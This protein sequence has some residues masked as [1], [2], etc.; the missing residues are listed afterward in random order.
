MDNTQAQSVGKAPLPNRSH[1]APGIS[2]NLFGRPKKN[3]TEA[4]KISALRGA[5]TG[6]I[7]VGSHQFAKDLQA[8]KPKDRLNLLM[9]MLRLVL[10]KPRPTPISEDDGEAAVTTADLL[11]AIYEREEDDDF[12]DEPSEVN[13]LLRSVAD[14]TRNTRSTRR[15]DPDEDDDFDEDD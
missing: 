5:V 4:D 14:G 10:P 1:W 9:Q 3:A 8:L 15:N 11:R 7:R 12:S 13:D 6:L 2:G